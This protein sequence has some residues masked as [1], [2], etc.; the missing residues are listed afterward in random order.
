MVPSHFGDGVKL[1]V[2]R[3]VRHLL[4]E[5]ELAVTAPPRKWSR[6]AEIVALLGLNHHCGGGVYGAT[7]TGAPYATGAV[8][9]GLHGTGQAGDGQ[10]GQ[11]RP[12]PAPGDRCGGANCS[13][14]NQCC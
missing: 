3:P 6:Q 9:Q 13:N 10:A 11:D 7:G 14:N 4:R 2:T 5:E 1:R 12:P 8:V